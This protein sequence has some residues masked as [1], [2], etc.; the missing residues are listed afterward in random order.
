MKKP[1][2][3]ITSGFSQGELSPQR[4]FSSYYGNAL[5]AEGALAVGCC[6]SAPSAAAN[7]FDGLLLSG[8]ADIAPSYY[9]QHATTDT[10][11]IDRRRDEEEFSI[12][13]AFVALKK[14]VFAICRGIQLLN[15]YF[16]GTLIQ[17]MQGHDGINHEV[18][19]LPDSRLHRLFGSSI[20][21]NSYHHQAI[22][23]VGNDLR[24]TARARDGIV[25]AVEHHTLPIFGV[26][27]HP[28]RQTSAT[29][30][31]APDD[32]GNLFAAFLALCG[33]K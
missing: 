31:D 16:G 25:E 8:G 7:Q 6:G 32:Q 21:T 27:W 20:Q 3:L 30:M 5:S 18:H 26:Q 4:T 33:G 19:L 15:V 28:E 17:D 29:C 22:D 2:I 12:L 14:P 24:V 9:G 13:D 11:S 10:L 1:V 23:A